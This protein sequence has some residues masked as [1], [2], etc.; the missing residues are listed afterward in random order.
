MSEE[1]KGG[2][3]FGIK[4]SQEVC[5]YFELS[6]TIEE[7]VDAWAAADDD[8]LLEYRQEM[9]IA[10]RNCPRPLIG[11]RHYW[12]LPGWLKDNAERIIAFSNNNSRN[13]TNG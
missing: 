9:N 5:D 3:P 1:I 12:H 10:L 11:Y 4:W 8:R 7:F 2:T 6:F 13:I